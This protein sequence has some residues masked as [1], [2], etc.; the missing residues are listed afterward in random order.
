MAFDELCGLLVNWG[1]PSLDTKL[2]GL[3]EH[4]AELFEGLCWELGGTWTVG[5]QLV[6]A[7]QLQ[8]C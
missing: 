3:T 1:P 4:R 6:E 2:A 7:H 5:A 8:P